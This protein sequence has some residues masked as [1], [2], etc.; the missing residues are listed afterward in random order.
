M[1]VRG[2]SL[3]IPLPQEQPT[4]KTAFR[5]DFPVATFF[6]APPLPPSEERVTLQPLSVPRVYTEPTHL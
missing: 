4:S 1:E 2:L 5:E 3:P 6:W